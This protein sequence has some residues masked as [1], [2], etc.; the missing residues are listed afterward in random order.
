MGKISIMHNL[1]KLL[2][3]EGLEISEILLRQLVNV[4]EEEDIKCE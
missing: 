4:V 1:I 2:A 3:W